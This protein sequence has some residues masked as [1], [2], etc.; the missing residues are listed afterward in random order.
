MNRKLVGSISGLVSANAAAQLVQFAIFVLLARTLG[1]AEF[2]WFVMALLVSNLG[3]VIIDFGSSTYFTRELAFGRVSTGLFSSALIL[4]VL[5]FGSGLI[6]AATLMHFLGY[7]VASGICLVILSQYIFQAIQAVPKSI[8]RTG[9][10]SLGIIIDR[11]VCLCVVVAFQSANGLDVWGGLTSWSAGQICGMAIIVLGYYK[12]KFEV[13]R[14]NLKVAFNLR[15]F[16]HLGFSSLSNIATSFDQII[17]GW[18]GGSQQTG[19]YGAVA[20]WFTPVSLLSSSIS[21]I[22]SNHAAKHASNPWEA[23]KK[24]KLLW[25]FMVALSAIVATSGP[26][27]LLGV[28]LLLGPDYMQSKSLIPF[29]AISSALMFLNLP[30]GALLQYFGEDKFVSRVV[31]TTGLMYLPLV[32]GILMVWPSNAA[33]NMIYGQIALQSII[34]L[35]FLSR[36]HPGKRSNS[37]PQA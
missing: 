15:E 32:A 2:G 36:L 30:L 20:K 25:V 8:N 7:Q 16:R 33:V 4:R 23:L 11:V 5:V 19:I 22:S 13:K 17:L 34:N 18:I 26:I 14:E 3:T 28:D 9:F 29:L 10:L 27:L 37:V 31:V 12:H 24:Q 6:A 1:P 35:S 21:T